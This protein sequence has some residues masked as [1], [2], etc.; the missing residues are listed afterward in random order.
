MVFVMIVA[1]I[2]PSISVGGVDFYDKEVDIVQ[3]VHNRALESTWVPIREK[4][5]KLFQV[6]RGNQTLLFL[7][8]IE[9]DSS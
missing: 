2:I 5:V 9:V 3:I 8:N 1:S 6:R 7:Y 4:A